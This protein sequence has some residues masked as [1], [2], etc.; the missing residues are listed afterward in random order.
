MDSYKSFEDMHA[1]KK[2]KEVE[3]SFNLAIFSEI[4]SHSQSKIS[5]NGFIIEEIPTYGNIWREQQTLDRKV[6][7]KT[8]SNY[9]KK[10]T[11]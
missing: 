10:K 2:R 5:K 9:S 1:C 4:Q 6:P 7:L 11:Y 8:A 3:Q